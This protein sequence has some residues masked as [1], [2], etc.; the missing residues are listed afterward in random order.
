[1]PACP[2][3]APGSTPTA[4]HA[5]SAEGITEM[6]P[7][8][9]MFFDLHQLGIGACGVQD[10]AVSVLAQVVG[11]NRILIDAGALALSKDNGAQD[12]IPDSSYGWVFDRLGQA[13][14]G[15]H[16][17]TALS[18]EHG[19]IESDGPLPFDHLP[20][21][22]RV[23]ILPSHSCLTVAAYGHYNLVDGGTTVIDVWERMGGW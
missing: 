20:I 12:Q 21:G 18:Q 4:V 17:V 10:I 3:V 8:N 16:R 22:T 2:R 6:R 5:Q 1:M 7:G 19:T 15:D 13:R 14:I 11:H 9:Y 23:R